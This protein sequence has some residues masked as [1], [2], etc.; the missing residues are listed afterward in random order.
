MGELSLKNVSPINTEALQVDIIR[1]I[2]ILI[3][4]LNLRSYTCRN[5]TMQ[6]TMN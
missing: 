3:I 4:S 6:V 1:R 5:S 2:D